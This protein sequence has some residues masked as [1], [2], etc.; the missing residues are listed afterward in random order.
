MKCL[1][2]GMTFEKRT[3]YHRYCSDAC[4]NKAQ[5]RGLK[6]QHATAAFSAY[7]FDCRNCGDHIIVMDPDDHRSVYCSATCEKAYWRRVSK[8]P[9]ALTVHYAWEMQ[10]AEARDAS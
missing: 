10:V 7:E 3:S 2:C 1:M 6:R 8:K 4:R 5:T 9:T